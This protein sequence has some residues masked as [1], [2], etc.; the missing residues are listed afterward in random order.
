MPTA[1][2]Y[3][4]PS[5]G[6]VLIATAPKFVRVSGYPHTHPYTLAAGSSPPANAAA[7]GTGTV[8]FA[9]G[10]PTAAQT[11]TV[12]TEVW[13]FA[14]THV[15]PFDVVIGGTNLLTASSFASTVNAN[16]QLV[17]ASVAGGVVT[18]TSKAVGTQG[19]YNLSTNATNVSVGAAALAGG[20]A[21]PIGIYMCHKPFWNNVTMTE[22]LYAR[23]QNPV[24]NSSNMD[25][26]LRLDVITV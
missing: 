15:S 11:V 2:I 8:T 16:S 1:N 20:A 7:A 24:P 13:V 5:D 9:T 26:K 17:T 23:V 10:V 6:W 3:I 18:L 4:A 14:A 12:G 19:N 22:N 21:R 25:G